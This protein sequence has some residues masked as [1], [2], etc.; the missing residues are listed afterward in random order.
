VSLTTRGRFLAATVT[1]LVL[2]AVGVGALLLTGG[3]ATIPGTG[4]TIGK[5]PDTSAK[6]TPPPI[7]P[8][9]GKRP[10]GGDVPNRPAL[11][12]KVENLPAARPQT[13]LSWADIVYEEPVEAGITR[14][15]AVYQCEDASRVEP[16]RSAR[17]TDPNIL[18]QFGRPAFGYAGGVPEV[19]KLVSRRGLID[20][21]FNKFLKD[22]P[23]D[24]DRPPPHD[25]YTN[26]RDLYE[27]A[28]SPDGA[29]QPIFTYSGKR[30]SGKK[31]STV[32]LPFSPESDVFWRWDAGRKAWLRFHGDTP[33]TLSDGTQVSTK[34]VVVQV[35]KIVYPGQ[36][37]VNGVLSPE[38]VS[39]GSGK[40]YVFRNGRVIVGRWSR[41]S[42][43][44]VTTFRDAQGNAIALA[45]GTTWVELLPGAIPVSYE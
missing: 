42:L 10:K 31:V 3:R 11:A 36:K 29:P 30:P 19:I 2:A 16:V 40:A 44:D 20:V 9:T 35:V 41:P 43:Q 39:V 12:I 23:R 13:G 17:L 1:V 34:N 28:N 33:H 26:T 7:C 18:V 14:F 27:D 4:I 21:N 25:V 24:P 15:I 5:N 6:P 38:A 45:P 22:Y 8:L 37:D 32:H